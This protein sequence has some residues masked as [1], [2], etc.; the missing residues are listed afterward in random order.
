MARHRSTVTR[1]YSASVTTRPSQHSAPV[2]PPAV[3]TN[4]PTPQFTHHHDV[5]APR[6]DARVFHPG[7]RVQTRL[8]SLF[9]AGRI[10]RNALDAACIWRSWAET[11]TPTRVQSWDVRV[12]APLSPNDTPMMRRVRAAAKLREVAEALGPLR[13]AILEA[14]IVRDRSWVELGRL[15]RLSDKAAKDRVVEALEALA[16]WCAGRTVAPM[17]EIRFRNQP[18]RL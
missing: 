6:V 3:A 10:D 5:A 11:I 9:E 7:W 13:V 8:L 4:R 15:L 12:D 17:P 14:V 2:P 16:D 18:S 1:S